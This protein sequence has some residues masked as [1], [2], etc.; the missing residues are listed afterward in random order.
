MRSADRLRAIFSGVEVGHDAEV[1]LR[2]ASI[3]IA[4]ACDCRRFPL[5]RPFRCDLC[6]TNQDRY[7]EQQRVL[8][9][10][11]GSSWKPMN[12]PIRTLKQFVEAKAEHASASS[13]LLCRG[14]FLAGK[15]R[16]A[17]T[18][19]WSSSSSFGENGRHSWSVGPSLPP[20]TGLPYGRAGFLEVSGWVLRPSANCGSDRS[21]LWGDFSWRGQ[22]GK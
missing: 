18:S 10:N 20:I 16:T 2:T 13:A 14:F 11:R 22:F 8:R 9:A 17:T 3:L 7:A 19:S 21:R 4:S 6:A 1:A 15:L 12:C 5:G